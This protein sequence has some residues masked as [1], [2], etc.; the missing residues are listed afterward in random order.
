M[1]RAPFPYNEPEPLPSAL[2]SPDLCHSTP[3]GD[4]LKG[5]SDK[6][7]QYLLSRKI[8]LEMHDL[9]AFL[10]FL[11][12]SGRREPMWMWW[13]TWPILMANNWCLP[14]QK[15]SFYWYALLCWYP[16]LYWHYP[17]IKISCINKRYW[18]FLSDPPFKQSPQGV[19]WHKSGE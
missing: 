7:I 15:Q 12:Q 8:D 14:L 4:C 6:K 16:I 9:L 17:L 13:W 19:L 3:W 5:G 18:I 1:W 10:F 11:K 2:Y